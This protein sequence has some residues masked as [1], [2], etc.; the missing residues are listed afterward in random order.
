VQLDNFAESIGS[1]VYVGLGL[2]FTRGTDH[3]GEVLFLHLPG[4]YR[5]Q[6]LAALVNSHG[7][8]DDKHQRYA[9]PD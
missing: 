5:H 7:D 4:L 8:D 2:D 3:R 6:I 9:N 1:D